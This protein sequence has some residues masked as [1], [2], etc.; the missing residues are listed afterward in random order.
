M[1]RDM[2]LIR[3]IVLAVEDLPH[4]ETLNQ[5]EDVD[6]DDFALHAEWLAE[7]GLIKVTAHAS[8]DGTPTVFIHRLTGD[9]CEFASSVRSDTLWKKAKENVLKPTSSFTF[10]LLKEWLANELTNGFPTLR[11][12]G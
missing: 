5:L 1:K 10:S 9:G 3:Q 8:F 2:D 4:R 6:P 12:E 11:G 7:A